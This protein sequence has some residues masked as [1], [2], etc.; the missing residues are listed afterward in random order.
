MGAS[1][2]AFL[3]NHDL[4]AVSAPGVRYERKPAR[5]PDGSTVACAPPNPS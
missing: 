4:G 5:R 3:K 1:D 2:T